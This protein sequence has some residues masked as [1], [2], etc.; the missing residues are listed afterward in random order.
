VVNITTLRDDVAKASSYRRLAS[1]AQAEA[2]VASVCFKHGP[3]ELTGVEL[4]WTLHHR[5]DLTRELSAAAIADALGPHAPAT[6]IPDHKPLPLPHGSLITVEPGG[7]VEISTPPQNS[8]SALLDATAADAA[9]LAQLLSAAGY[10]LGTAGCDPHRPPRRLLNT[11]RYSA[12]EAAFAPLGADGITMM[13]STAGIQVCLDAGEQAQTPARWAALHLLGP[14][15]NAAFANSSRLGGRVTAW[16]S[17]RQRVLFGT[18]PVR[19]RPSAVSA[20]PAAA[21]ARRVLDTPVICIRRPGGCWEPPAR[22][23]FADWLDGA[24]PTPPTTED[25]DYHLSTLF[26]PVRPRGYLEVRYIDAQPDGGWVAPSALLTALLARESTV[27]AVLD[28]AAPAAGR[29]LHAARYG[30]ADRRIAQAANGVLEL[31]VPALWETDLSPALIHSI[32]ESVHRRMAGTR[33][34]VHR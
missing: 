14:V 33:E 34:G 10:V 27:D 18:D 2:Y 11:P 32:T 30:L 26:P 23:T 17:I 31:G 13:C 5:R 6:L 1:R 3:P 29:W 9:T 12:M 7:Q 15:F 16:S 25:L 20:D 4:E 19:M 22:L 21:W 8:L 28:A 24:L